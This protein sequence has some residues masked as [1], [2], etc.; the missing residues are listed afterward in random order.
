[1]T[2]DDTTI[3]EGAGDGRAIEGRVHQ[4]RAEIERTDSDYDREK[5]P[6][7]LAKMAGG[8]A[9]IKVGAATE[10]ELKERKH[11]IEDAVRNAKAAVE[12]GIVP[13][14][15]VALLHAAET[16][17]DKLDVEGEEATGVEMVRRALSAPLRQIAANA[18]LE[19]GVVVEK[20]RSLPQGR[21]LNAATGEVRRHAGRGHHRPG[22]GDPLRP[23]ASIA[24]LFLTTEA[25]VAD[26]PEEE[27]EPATVGAGA[28]F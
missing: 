23:A 25:V 9:V 17:F 8:V 26:Q 11:R 13:G 24:G 22:E 16:A 3:V 2:K 15:G 14:G 1:M 28:D 27:K 20:V 12:E 6:E 5:L 18:G 10:V 4:I 21:G 7:R 19:G